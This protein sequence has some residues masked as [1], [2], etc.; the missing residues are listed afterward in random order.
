MNYNKKRLISNRNYN[1]IWQFQ[2]LLGDS[3]WNGEMLSP[4]YNCE[5]YFLK[6]LKKTL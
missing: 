4:V 1:S 6:Y 5:K 3:W 2:F